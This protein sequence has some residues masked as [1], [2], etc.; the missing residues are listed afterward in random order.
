[1]TE[2]IQADLER[3]RLL[4]SQQFMDTGYVNAEV[5]ASSQQRFGIDVV[6]PTHPDAKWQAATEGGI[7]ASQ[8]LIN[9][10]RKQATCPQGQTSQLDAHT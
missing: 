4:P 7:D 3:A 9:W 1:M 2:C 8:F 10:E 5:L 6:S